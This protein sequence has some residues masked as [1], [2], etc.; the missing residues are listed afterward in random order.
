MTPTTAVTTPTITAMPAPAASHL[1]RASMFR[2]AMSQRIQTRRGYGKESP[3]ARFRCLFDCRT[4]AGQSI[5]AFSETRR[6]RM[7][8]FPM[9]SAAFILL[10]SGCQAIE[11]AQER[12]HAA[13]DARD[14][15]TCQSYGITAD[16]SRCAACRMLIVQQRSEDAYR[17]ALIGQMNAQRQQQFFYNQMQMMNNA[18]N[19]NR[20]ASQSSYCERDPS[21]LYCYPMQ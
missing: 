15:A 1:F 6:Y 2:L 7:H 11:A 20:S 13:Q 21:G 4:G 8:A 12:A 5:S 18:V 19:Q 16:D 9:A 14:D 17:A 10:L 3:T